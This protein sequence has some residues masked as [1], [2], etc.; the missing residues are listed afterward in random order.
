MAHDVFI[1]HSSTD[2]PIADAICANLERAE[3]RCWVAPRDIA[4]GLDW[5]TAISN[6]IASSRVM[7][8]V[9]SADAN[10]S[11]E[12]GRELTMAATRG[13][14]VIPFRIDN[15]APEPGKEY[16]LGRTHWLDAL[17]PPTQ[18]Q[19]D[20]LVG[21]VRSFLA[22]PPA[23]ASAEAAM[24]AVVAPARPAPPSGAVGSVASSSPQGRGG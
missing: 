12:I 2:K 7:V 17:N 24:G 21:Y 14:I 15:V 1:S 5:P 4:P 9:F 20:V 11:V 3:I 18:E 16:Y 13:V 6:A 8:L 22:G 23:V 10:S 19:I